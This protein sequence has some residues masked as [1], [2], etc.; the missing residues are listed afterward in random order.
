MSPQDDAADYAADEAARI[1]ALQKMAPEVIWLQVDPEGNAC[2]SEWSLLDG[3]TWCADKI[4]NTDVEYTK[5]ATIKTL[6]ALLTTEK[7]RADYAWR[8]TNTIEK[9]RQDEMAKRDELLAALEYLQQHKLWINSHAK[10]VIEAAIA[11]V[12]P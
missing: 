5:G 10:A 12:K 6:E 8:N 11:K 4:N 7:E 1:A 9:A 3:A 2:S